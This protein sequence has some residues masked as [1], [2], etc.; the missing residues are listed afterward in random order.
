MKKIIER[1]DRIEKQLDAISKAMGIDDN[2][3]I[4]FEWCI[5]RENRIDWS[6]LP[7]TACGAY[8]LRHNIKPT[9]I[10]LRKPWPHL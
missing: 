4:Q 9:V 8:D 7:P 5:V 2:A 3:F 10:K 1:L 6:P